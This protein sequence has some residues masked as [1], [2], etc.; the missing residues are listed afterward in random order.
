MSHYFQKV[1][2]KITLTLFPVLLFLLPS[3]LGLHLWP[4]YAFVFG[5]R[6]DYL[7]ITLYSINL[8]I[9]TFFVLNISTLKKQFQTKYSQN[10]I[11]IILLLFSINL[12]FSVNRV[13]SLVFF[14]NLAVLFCF[15]CLL[16]Q[17]ARFQKYI[18]PS[19]I[20]SFF[21]IVLIGLIQFWQGS[22][23]DGVFWFLGERHFNQTTSGIALMD[24]LGVEHLRAYSIFSHPN[25]FA[26]FAVVLWLI[27][28]FLTQ[29]TLI[30][31]TLLFGALAVALV[32]TNSLAVCLSL[33]IS[34]VLSTLNKRFGT[35]IISAVFIVSLLLLSLSQFFKVNY[36]DAV[37]STRGRISGI[38]QSLKV[39]N[40]NPITGVGL[41]NFIYVYKQEATDLRYVEPVHNLYL[42]VFSETGVLGLTCLYLM[43]TFWWFK[44]SE[45]KDKWTFLLKAGFF[46]ILLTGL[47]EFK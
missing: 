30:Q 45:S 35:I 43:F 3:Q 37:Y 34:L 2:S 33:P 38:K 18:S 47:F 31:L 17:F 23:I 12:L 9:V 20:L 36:G 21:V 1:I 44:L 15:Y 28:V 25:S 40:K 7:A 27:V 42:L 5:A 8:L 4:P 41:G 11:T 26:S 22:S 16:T 19:L 29:L 39:V 46:F 32:T 10:L 6:S 13:S 14:L 24:F